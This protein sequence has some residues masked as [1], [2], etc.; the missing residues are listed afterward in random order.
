[1]DLE[2]GRARLYL[3]SFDCAIQVLAW[4]LRL[5]R[6]PG[7]TGAG[8]LYVRRV[9]LSV[10]Y[11]FV[12]GFG[13]IYGF[14]HQDR[15]L[16]PF[17]ECGTCDISAFD[18]LYLAIFWML[19][20][21]FY[22]HWP[23]VWFP[24]WAPRCVPRCLCRFRRVSSQPWRRYLQ[25]RLWKVVGPIPACS[26]TGTMCALVGF[27]LAHEAYF[28]CSELAIHGVFTVV[29]ACLN[30]VDLQHLQPGLMRCIR[31]SCLVLGTG[32]SVLGSSGDCLGS[33]VCLTAFSLVVAILAEFMILW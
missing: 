1:M 27:P 14:G 16:L 26:S 21:A 25:C 20:T 15:A 2:L 24:W 19:N 6:C 30:E 8:F 4:R 12:C 22:W 29:G 5:L 7:P 17:E 10:R 18:G 23:V 13:T 31:H 11:R 3:G 9:L 28:G 33:A 32:L